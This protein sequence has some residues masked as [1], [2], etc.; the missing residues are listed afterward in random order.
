ML[1]MSAFLQ[2]ANSSAMYWIAALLVAAV[3]FQSVLFLRKSYRRGIAIGMSPEVLKKTAISSAA[4]S[5]IP[6]IGIL[7]GVLALAPS[8][9][10]PVPWVRLSVIGALQ[11]EGSTANNLAK[12]MG[13]GELPSSKMTG[14]DLSAIAFGMTVCVLSG[15]I[16]TLL[17]LKSYQKKLHKS[18]KKNAKLSNL[19]FGSM[20]IGMI[21][22]YLG[23]AC[24]YLRN[25][26][27]SGQ[28]RT[29]NILPLIAFITAGA[30][31]ALFRWL[32]EKKKISW[33][34][35]YALSFAMVIGM[36]AAVLGQ[37]VFP[38]LSAFLN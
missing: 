33:L 31:M 37:F 29:P 6:S 22:A 27:V 13:L 10:I 36:A 38:N 25:V 30:S 34:E 28:T 16:F 15:T 19:L 32:I 9:G 35:N 23:D 2:K 17:F 5:F 14:G 18:E 26:Q 7:I 3:L 11:Y 1:H 4:F 12:G 8:L 21:S 20:F 24:S